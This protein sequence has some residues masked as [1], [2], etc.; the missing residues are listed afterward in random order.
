MRR[1]FVSAVV[2]LVTA[3]GLRA[4]HTPS[5]K[6]VMQRIAEYVG[7]YGEQASIVVATERYTQDVTSNGSAVPAT[8]AVVAEFAIVKVA[9]LGEWIG[10]RDV[11]EVDGRRV[12]DREDRLLHALTTAT[13]GFDEAKRISD[14]SARFNIGPVLRNFNVPTA[15]LFFFTA[16]HAGRFK[17]ARKDVTSS[18][19]W[20][21]AFHE[22][23][24]PTL[25]RTPDGASVPA[26][27]TL[28]VNPQDGTILRTRLELSGFGTPA[29]SADRDTH[30]AIDV[31]YQHVD[32]LDMWLPESMIEMFEGSRGSVVER[33]RGEARY[34]NYRRFETSGRIR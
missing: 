5:L 23:R 4:D 21:V 33:T 10:F 34:S 32:A 9:G 17:F 30:G 8:R 19:V 15:A 1:F 16:D 31:T 11:V 22:T 18:G 13:G 7:A 29:R 14:E 12:T 20:E 25:I 26:A 27:G 2:L 24:H 28:W 6:T 3:A